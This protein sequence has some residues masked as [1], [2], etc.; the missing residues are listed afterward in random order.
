MALLDY[1]DSHPLLTDDGELAEAYNAEPGHY[2]PVPSHRALAWLGED[3][4]LK[5]LKA[6][7]AVVT[8]DAQTIAL[9]SAVDTLLL[10]AGNPN[11]EL[12]MHPG[13][14]HRTMLA[15][16]SQGEPLTP[17]DAAALIARG[18]R[19][20]FTPV[21]ADDVAAGR[22]ELASRA[23]Q[24]ALAN[25]AA[26]LASWIVGQETVPTGDEVKARWEQA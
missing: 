13:S 11:A 16:L 12:E 19:P 25:R 3:A 18:Y 14:G 5:R 17:D 10:A 21:T 9:Q 23:E 8:E 4:R 2:V 6:F 1:I 26:S 24:A 20:G 7:I 22:L 15:Y